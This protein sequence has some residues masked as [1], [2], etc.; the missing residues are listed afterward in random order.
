MAKSTVLTFLKVGT[1]A[2]SLNKIC[3]IK[4]YPAAGSQ[5]ESLDTTTLEDSTSTSCP[6]VQQLESMQFTMNWDKTAYESWKEKDYLTTTGEIFYQL[7]FGT[8]GA[9]GVFSWKGTHS[10]APS[11]GQVNGV[12]E[13]TLTVFP[14]TIIY[15]KKASEAFA[16]SASS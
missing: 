11:E 6:G 13:M 7:E 9:D 8:D 12:R 5:P 15:A 3:P 1:A 16:N 4:S 14:S 2:S 10:I